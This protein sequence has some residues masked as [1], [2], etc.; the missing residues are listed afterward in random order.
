MRG[1][2]VSLEIK[3][4]CTVRWRQQFAHAYRLASSL[5]ARDVLLELWVRNRRDALV[6]AGAH[7]CYASVSQ[8]RGF[9]HN[10]VVTFVI[11]WPLIKGST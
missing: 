9:E 3:E 6:T 5:F 10:T 1:V 11:R 2:G 4:L 8:G 7:R